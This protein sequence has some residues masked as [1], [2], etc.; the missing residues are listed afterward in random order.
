MGLRRAAL[1]ALAALAFG[2]F[3]CANGGSP[4]AVTDAGVDRSQHDSTV[5]LDG[6]RDAPAADSAKQDAAHDAPVDAPAAPT[7]CAINARDIVIN[8]I[9]YAPRSTAPK[10]ALRHEYVELYNR[11]DADVSLEGWHIIDETKGL[12]AQ[13]PTGA[14]ALVMPAKSILLV[15]AATALTDGNIVVDRDLSDGRGLFVALQSTS[16]S[17][18]GDTAALYCSSLYLP[19]TLVDFVSFDEHGGFYNQATGYGEDNPAVDD[20]AVTA[21][22]W[23]DGYAVD[24]LA[25]GTTGRTL[26]LKVDG[27][28]PNRATEPGLDFFQY[29]ERCWDGTLY[30]GTPGELNATGCPP[31]DGGVDAGPPPPTSCEAAARD[32]VINEI[33]YAAKTGDPVVEVRYEYVELYNRGATAVSLDGWRIVSRYLALWAQL[34]SGTDAITLPP[35]AF[36]AVFPAAASA[37]VTQDLDFTDLRGRYLAPATSGS[38][39]NAGDSV[40]VYCSSVY[41]AETIVDFVSYSEV[42]GTYDAAAGTGEY[43]PSVDEYAVQAGIWVKGY[44]IDVGSGWQGRALALAADGQTPNETTVPGLDWIQYTDVCPNS[45]VL[46]GGTPGAPNNGCPVPDGGLPDAP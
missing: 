19:D 1:A 11:G 14:G 38:F 2:G 15:V 17:N 27:A 24:T 26:A 9:N 13:L 45:S 40:Q 41:A 43:D 25:S 5:A 4:A 3:A 37:D 44:A 46:L 18:T 32:V 22:M 23:V 10:P 39:S 8:E 7:S 36:L 16:F 21:G 30:L 34:P 20:D 12:W 33:S 28:K 42:G 6:P 35:G 31:A 29:P